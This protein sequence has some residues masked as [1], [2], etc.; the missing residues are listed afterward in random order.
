[1]SSNISKW[2]R[3]T[4]IVRNE[5]NIL[6]IFLG[7]LILNLNIFEKTASRMRRTPIAGNQPS[8]IILL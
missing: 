5:Q 1:M 7:K 2:V 3:Y 6:L 4:Q 8:I